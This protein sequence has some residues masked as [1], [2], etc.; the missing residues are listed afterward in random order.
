MPLSLALGSIVFYTAATVFVG[1]RLFVEP[2]GDG[3]SWQ[4]LAWCVALA[5]ALHA[6]LLY[7]MVK[8]SGGLDLG[9]F[10][11]ATMMSW[12]M[13]AL[14]GVTSLLR[15]VENL[16]VFVLPLAA[17][18]VALNL[19]G[20]DSQ[21]MS[22]AHGVGIRVHIVISVLAY[23]LL[24]LAACQALVLAY[25]DHRLRSKRL[26]GVLRVL[27]PLQAQEQLLFQLVGLGFF[28]LSLSLVSGF[29]FVEDMFA[30]HLAH[31]TVLA[32]FAWA[33][34][35]GLLW[36]RWR[37]GWRGATA[38]R[39]SLA[40]FVI[41]ALAYFGSKIVLEIMLGRSWGSM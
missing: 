5:L 20:L 18:T 37:H 32:V 33:V 8:Q 41:L 23:G 2:A 35:G 40:G 6:G 21:P 38:I 16:G 34:F 15:P 24:T 3:E 10:A 36:G 29:M 27:P 25:Q 39:W 28:M 17:L 22:T 1:R 7:L 11:V 4:P 13:V 12:V 14:V 31:K 30:Q 19:T 9:L 26:G